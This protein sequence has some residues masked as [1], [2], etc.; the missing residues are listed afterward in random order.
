MILE[1][2]RKI[3]NLKNTRL[4]TDKK[5]PELRIVYGKRGR[6]TDPSGLGI[7]L[8]HI[9]VSTSGVASKVAPLM[10]SLPS[11][12]LAFSLHSPF[13]GTQ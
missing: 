1:W 4:L 3:P 9:T 2:I 10:A 5:I 7:A 6:V 12:R 11:V 8:S 13:K